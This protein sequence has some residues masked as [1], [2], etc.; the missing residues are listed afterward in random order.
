MKVDSPVENE[1]NVS[2]EIKKI[3]QKN[4]LVGGGFLF[5]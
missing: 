3:I 2:I 1:G 5:R 4:N